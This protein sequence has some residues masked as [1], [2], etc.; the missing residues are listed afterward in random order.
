MHLLVSEKLL[1][2]DPSIDKS[3]AVTL[4]E[5]ILK[6]EVEFDAE[7]HVHIDG[8]SD[9]AEFVKDMREQ[10]SRI[11]TYYCNLISPTREE[12]RICKSK[13]SG[14]LV[15]RKDEVLRRKVVIDSYL[16]VKLEKLDEAQRRQHV[17][18][19]QEVSTIVELENALLKFFRESKGHAK[20]TQIFFCT[21]GDPNGLIVLEQERI[22]V[23]DTVNFV[24]KYYNGEPTALIFTHCFSYLGEIPNNDGEIEL[25]FLTSSK[26]PK[27]NTLTTYSLDKKKRR[28]VL[29]QTSGVVSSENVALQSFAMAN[30]SNPL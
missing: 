26:K 19:S 23:E 6:C 18:V 15:S 25:I 28:N 17:A 21:H 22:S 4:A 8:M 16:K 12:S 24:K 14:I 9:F 1:K 7:N 29:R 2:E 11:E 13:Q 3:R 5:G 10:Y 20:T 30:Q 27:T